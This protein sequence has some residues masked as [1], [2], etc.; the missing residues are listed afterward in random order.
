[1][2]VTCPKCDCRDCRTINTVHHRIKNKEITRR[3]RVCRN[4]SA[5]FHTVEH[6]E[7]DE[8]PKSDSI[9]AANKISKNGEP[10]VKVPKN[11]YL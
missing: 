5:V 10:I 8:S 9:T 4:C 6:L 2:T 1:M 11:P 7:N 3:R